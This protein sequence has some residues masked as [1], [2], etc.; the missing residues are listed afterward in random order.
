MIAFY[1]NLDYTYEARIGR[2]LDFSPHLHKEAE[3]IYVLSGSITVQ[4]NTLY[5]TLSANEIAMILPNTI[6]SYQC[7][8]DCEIGILIFDVNLAGDY[9]HLLTQSDCK[10]PFLEYRSDHRE[11]LHC[12]KSIVREKGTKETPVVKGYITVILGRIIPR[13][14]LSPVTITDSSNLMQKMLVYVTEHYREPLSLQVLSHALGTS[15]YYISRIF[16]DKIGCNFNFYVNSL[17]V[18]HAKDL[19]KNKSLPITMVAYECGFES[20][21]SFNR[22]FRQICKATPRDYRRQC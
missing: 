2:G 18:N 10:N 6:H 20:Q 8:A 15:T 11:L 14:T 1:E 3:I 13:L 5:R 21:R 4:V 22:V 12:I 17:R 16:S 7:T 9:T 19:L